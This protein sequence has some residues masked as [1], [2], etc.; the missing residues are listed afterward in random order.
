MLT[1]VSDYC[2][3]C[4]IRKGS[5]L[6]LTLGQCMWAIEQQAREIDVQSFRGHSTPAML[7]RYTASYAAGETA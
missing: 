1:K 3:G 4:L 6:R 5:S 7:G 2:V